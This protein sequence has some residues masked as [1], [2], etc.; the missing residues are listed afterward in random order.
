MGYSCTAVANRVLDFVLADLSKNTGNGT[1]N[2]WYYNINWYNNT[3]GYNTRTKELFFEQDKENADGAITGQVYEIYELLNL[4]EKRVRKIWSSKAISRK[5]GSVRIEPDGTITRF[6][7]I[8]ASLRKLA[9][10]KLKNGVFGSLYSL[11]TI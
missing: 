10:S 9:M 6:F 5:L 3:N 8:P 2:G 1:S 7:G 11:P 4:S